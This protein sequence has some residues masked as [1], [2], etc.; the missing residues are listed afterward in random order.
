MFDDRGLRP[1]RQLKMVAI[2]RGVDFVA[3]QTLSDVHQQQRFGRTLVTLHADMRHAAG[4]AFGQV[5][6]DLRL[7]RGAQA[8][9]IVVYL[10]LK[11]ALLERVA[12]LRAELTVDKHQAHGIHAHCQRVTLCRREIRQAG[13]KLGVQ[14]AI[15]RGVLPVL[16]LTR[17]QAKTQHL[18]QMLLRLLGA[19]AALGFKQPVPLLERIT[20]VR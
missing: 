12:Q 3:V 4:Q 18:L 8:L 9:A 16:M 1:L 6:K 13:H 14:Q 10:N 20:A 2:V 15:K 17:R 19:R 5:Q 7:N 11:A